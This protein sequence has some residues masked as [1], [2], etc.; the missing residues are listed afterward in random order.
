MNNVLLKVKMEREVVMLSKN[1]KVSALHARG[2]F[3]E[4]N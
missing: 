2:N 4:V 3:V 1:Y